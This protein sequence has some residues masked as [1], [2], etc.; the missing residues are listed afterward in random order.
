M[1]GDGVVTTS[2]KCKV[3]KHRKLSGPRPEKAGDSSK[4]R[5]I[6]S[7]FQPV[8]Y[9]ARLQVIRNTASGL[10]TVQMH[11]EFSTHYAGHCIADT[12][13]HSLCSK[14]DEFIK[15]EAEKPYASKDISDV[16]PQIIAQSTSPCRAMALGLGC[17][18]ARAVCNKR[19]KERSVAAT[20]PSSLA[21]DVVQSLSEVE[22]AGYVAKRF[23]NESAKGK[24]LPLQ[25]LAGLR[26]SL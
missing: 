25:L 9:E 23:L 22:T 12:D 11:P 15:E 1:G 6:T 21:E 2:Y 14:A 4:K 20:P 3:V 17:I 5:R 13:D 7:V 24:V 19:W 26:P 16:L 10:F 8:D 18:T